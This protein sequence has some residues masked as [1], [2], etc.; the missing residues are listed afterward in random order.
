[1]R[2]GLRLTLGVLSVAMLFFGVR[3]L[4]KRQAQKKREAA[5]Q[6]ILHLYQQVLKPGM[7]RKDVEEYLRANGKTFR[8]LCCIHFKSGGKHSWD[9]EVKIGQED[10]PWFCG[11][12]NVYIGL[13]FGDSEKPHDEFSR[14]DD[15]DT[16][17]SVSL[18]HQLEVCL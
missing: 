4:V 6:K 15:S 1:M 12:N 16:L 7:T 17:Q 18:S 14:A 3:S 13:E 10:P 9:D 8:Q 5:Y 11:E 2:H